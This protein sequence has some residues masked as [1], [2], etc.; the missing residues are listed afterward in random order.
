[1]DFDFKSSIEDESVEG[2]QPN[3]ILLIL[4]VAALFILPSIFLVPLM[5]LFPNQDVELLS[6]IAYFFGYGSYIVALGFLIGK[7][8][9]KK[10]LKGFNL[11]N[12]LVAL[13]FAFLLYVASILTS[14]LI[15]T[16]FGNVDSNAN[17][18][19]L[20]Q[21]MMKYT[22]IVSLFTV[23]FA[24]LVEELVFR[25]TIFR[26]IAKK[27]KVLAYIVSVLTFAGIHF[28]SS[29]SVLMT[30]LVNPDIAQEIAYASFYD[31]LKTLPI[32]MVAALIL[33]ISYDVNKNI[34]TN[35]MIH[36]MYNLSQV[37]IMIFLLKFMNNLDPTISN[38]S[39]FESLN[40]IKLL[41]IC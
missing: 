10:I 36:A 32:Y 34:A 40:Y 6:Y 33:T 28:I 14:N 16:I 7:D 26:P 24:P 1:M 35:I 13:L 3:V 30:D 25:F 5:L 19:S 23:V 2:L 15:T 37:L 38:S 20:D 18:E 12:F 39:I 4:G 8:K 22:L 27:S 11:N 41:L 21:G 31:D 17:Q 29:L 9:V